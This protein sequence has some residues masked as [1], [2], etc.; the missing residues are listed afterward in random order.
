MAS[1]KLKD[2][3]SDTLVLRADPRLLEVLHQVERGP[4]R[5]TDLARTLHLAPA[6]VNR[7]LKALVLGRLL[8][9]RIEAG[10]YPNKI[11]YSLTP[12][13]E[14]ELRQVR[15]RLAALRESPNP[16]HEREARR[17]QRVLA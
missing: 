16:A 17:L 10:T 9:A 3:T 7:A 4:L 12:A 6:Q 15:Q 11:R 8:E 2:I 5:F 13:G 14:F 1:R